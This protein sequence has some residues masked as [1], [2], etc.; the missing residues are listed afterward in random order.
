LI[1]AGG[2]DQSSSPAPIMPYGSLP[3]V[4]FAAAKPSMAFAAGIRSRHPAPAKLHNMA[5]G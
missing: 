5:V 2:K 3:A 4:T 1:F